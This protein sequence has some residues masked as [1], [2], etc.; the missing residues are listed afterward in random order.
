[1]GPFQIA[2][3]RG[4]PFHT[5]SRG[6]PTLTDSSRAMACF[7]LSEG[8]EANLATRRA[9]QLS[10]I[11]VAIRA[12]WNHRLTGLKTELGPIHIHL[13]H[14]RFEPHAIRAAAHFSIVVSIHPCSL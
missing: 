11:E 3:R 5:I 6:R 12:V 7:A 1:M 2:V 13:D 14:V 10:E 8:P 9:V 4:R